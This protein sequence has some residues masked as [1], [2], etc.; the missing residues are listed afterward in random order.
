MPAMRTDLARRLCTLTATSG[1]VVVLTAASGPAL[2]ACG[3]CPSV[4]PPAPTFHVTANGRC[5]ASIS[6]ETSS[7]CKVTSSSC[8]GATIDLTTN[9]DSSDAGPICDVVVVLDDKTVIQTSVAWTRGECCAWQLEPPGL[10]I[11]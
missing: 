8:G 1:V 6:A 3:C 4:D 7:T 10:V 2:V 5:I 9:P 11:D